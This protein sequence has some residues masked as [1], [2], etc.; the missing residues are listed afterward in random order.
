MKKRFA[1]GKLLKI[2]Q[3]SPRR[4]EPKCRYFGECGGCQYQH[5]EYA[6]QLEVKHKQICDIF[7]RL[8]RLDRAVVDAVVPCPSPYGYR[9]RIMIRSQWD[10][11]KQGLNIGYIRAD[12]PAG[13]S[14]SRECVIAE[15]ALNAQITDVRLHPPPKGRFESDAARGAGR[16]GRAAG[17]VLPE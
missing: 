2:T 1:R 11:F 3:A 7:E 4:V 15:P 12:K 14:I 6:A 17:F 9:N 13:P 8:G 5:L 16:L 10:K